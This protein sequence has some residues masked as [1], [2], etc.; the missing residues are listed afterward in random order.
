VKI[1]A[2][3]IE[4][5]PLTAH[6]WTLW[7]NAISINQL[8]ETQEIMCFAARW[9][10]SKKVEFHST[11]HHGK[12]AMLQAAWDL[13]NE[14][15]AVLS[16]NGKAFDSKHM[17]REFLQAGM[18]PPS[19][20]KEID[21]MV[22]VKKRFRFASAKLQHVSQQLGLEGKVETGGFELWLGCMAGDVKAWNKMRTY[23]RRDVDLLIDLYA[24]LLPW[25]DN[26]PSVALYDEAEGCPNC[27]SGDLR[28]EGFA[29]SNLGKY[30]RFQCRGCGRWSKSGKRIA[31]VE[32][33]SV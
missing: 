10:G 27:G 7:P 23:N 16:Y 13:L 11:F 31:G 6:T 12:E 5:S 29:F 28:K 4:T 17:M 20:Y 3:D 9:L 19:P 33:R 15:D 14:A 18:P 21:L 8:L 25:I 22:A 24:K 26:H 2:W 32:L 30:Q 1:L